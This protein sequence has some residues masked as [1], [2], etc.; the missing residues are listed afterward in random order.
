MW[1]A[2]SSTVGRGWRRTT[3]SSGTCPGCSTPA[4]SWWSTTR[5][6]SRRGCTCAN[7]PGGAVEVLLLE[8]HAAGP[9][10]WEALVRP[11]RKVAPGTRCT[12]VRDGVDPGTAVEVLDDLGEGRRL[13]CAS[14]TWAPGWAAELTA[15]DVM[16]DDAAAALHHR[17]PRAARAVPYLIY[18]ERGR[19][20]GRAHRR[21][22]PHRRGAGRPGRSGRGL[23]PGGAGRRAGHLPADRDRPD[24]GPPDAQRDLRGARGHVGP[25]ARHPRRRPRGGGRGHHL[26]ARPSRAPPPVGTGPA[27]RTCSSTATTRSPSSTGRRTELPPAGCSS[28]SSSSM[29][30]RAALA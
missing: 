23:R 5:G 1:R 11:S 14:S 30:S 29:P 18:A 28:S 17:P 6:C 9:S 27:A 26:A 16:G 4:T 22:P 2:P 13:S 24:R 10:C 20:G 15:I 12:S 3:A 21:A 8:P 25:G 19:L 7:R